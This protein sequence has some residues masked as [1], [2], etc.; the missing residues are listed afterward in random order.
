MSIKYC[1]LIKIIKNN[2]CIVLPNS[3]TITISIY[4]VSRQSRCAKHSV[5][6]ATPA[7][8]ASDSKIKWLSFSLVNDYE[9]K[10]LENICRNDEMMA[11]LKLHAKATQ[12]SNF[13]RSQTQ[14]FSLALVSLFNDERF[15]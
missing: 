6:R 11:A 15:Q 14:L 7:P 12:L 9:L 5:E 2:L 3:L 8:L 4:L 1:S 10:Q 13:K